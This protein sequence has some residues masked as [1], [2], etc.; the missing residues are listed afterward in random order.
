MNLLKI[1]FLVASSLCVVVN[2]KE[3]CPGAPLTSYGNGQLACAAPICIF[4][5]SALT[6]SSDPTKYFVCAGPNR[7]Y[8]MPCAP[9]TCFSSKEQ[10]CVH[11]WEWVEECQS[12]A[13]PVPQISDGDI[14]LTNSTVNLVG[15]DS[16]N[17]NWT[18]PENERPESW[19]S[20]TA[21]ATIFEGPDWDI[22]N[23]YEQQSLTEELNANITLISNIT[24]NA[25]F[26]SDLPKL[27]LL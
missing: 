9:G 7:Y 24:L 27:P 1:C 12:N 13:Y 10:T 16:T 22:I 15:S 2:G 5:G 25:N 19:V 6:P 21:N 18:S 17:N 23:Q 11:P 20:L 4:S 8:E 26:T 3:T 14:I